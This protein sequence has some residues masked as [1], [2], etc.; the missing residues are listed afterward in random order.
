M[1]NPPAD[2]ILAELRALREAYA[3]KFN[4]DPAA[5]AKDIQAM[6]ATSDGEYITL[7]SKPVTP[8][9]I[10]MLACLCGRPRETD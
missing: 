1:D 8:P 10:A 6:K 9:G 3:A 5:I 2:P 4:Y 7:S